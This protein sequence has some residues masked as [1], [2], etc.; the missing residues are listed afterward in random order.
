VQTPFRL[1]QVVARLVLATAA[2]AGLAAPASAAPWEELELASPPALRDDARAREVAEIVAALPVAS[3]S[4]ALVSWAD[5]RFADPRTGAP[6][7]HRRLAHEVFARAFRAE[8]LEARIGQELLA[9][10]EPNHSRAAQAWLERMRPVQV[11][12][13]A[14]AA[15]PARRASRSES[16]LAI[17]HLLL[18]RIEAALGGREAEERRMRGILTAMLFGANV[19][20]A[21]ERRIHPALIDG[22]VEA[23]VGA[24]RDTHPYRSL[25]FVN[26]AYRELPTA[27][28]QVLADFAE[29]P[30]GRWLFDGFRRGLDDAL[31]RAA[32]EAGAELVRAF[33]PS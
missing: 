33:D 28:L 6:D 9:S 21:P 7:E 32:Y 27:E 24:L 2:L 23:Q 19:E 16:D 29:S 5:A 22:T 31:E 17:R 26:E 12:S 15:V 14:D 30:A 3:I 13:L 18:Q 20:L 1:A 25:L 4:D 10:F 8:P 11:A